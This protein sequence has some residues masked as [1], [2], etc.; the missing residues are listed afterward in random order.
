MCPGCGVAGCVR[1]ASIGKKVSGWEGSWGC[2]GVRAGA[3]ARVRAR[4][5]GGLGGGGGLKMRTC[6]AHVWHELDFGTSRAHLQLSGFA[7]TESFGCH[8]WSQAPVVMRPDDLALRCHGRAAR[9]NAKNWSS[10]GLPLRECHSS[11][12]CANACHLRVLCYKLKPATPPARTPMSKLH[13]ERS[14]AARLFKHELKPVRFLSQ[15]RAELA[16]SA[17]FDAR[18]LRMLQGLAPSTCLRLLSACGSFVTVTQWELRFLSLRCACRLAPPAQQRQMQPLLRAPL[19]TEGQ[20]M[21]PTQQLRSAPDRADPRRGSR[22]QIRNRNKRRVFAPRPR[23]SPQRVHPRTAKTQNTSSFCTSTTQSVAKNLEFL[24]L[25]HADPR[26]GFIRAPQKRKKR[27]PQVFA[28][29]D[30]RRG[31]RVHRKNRKQKMTFNC[32]FPEQ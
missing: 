5:Y 29:A 27:K 17:N 9:R 30:P 3:S 4:A 1:P 12:S 25:D 31:S 7:L 20:N 22:G 13:K 28:R 16:N 32:F 2:A 21:A 24:Y 8:N 26:R 14:L 18:F 15:L 11:A 23:R 10:S 19:G 6:F